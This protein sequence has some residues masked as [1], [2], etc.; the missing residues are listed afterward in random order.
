MLRRKRLLDKEDGRFGFGLY[1]RIGLTRVV[2]RI[3]VRVR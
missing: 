3:R 2:A 1:L